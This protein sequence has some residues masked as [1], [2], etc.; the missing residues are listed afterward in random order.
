MS[1]G[2]W[3]DG[4]HGA[5][6][7]FKSLK[8]SALAPHLQQPLTSVAHGDSRHIASAGGTDWDGTILV[9]TGLTRGK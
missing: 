5:E 1:D 8:G 2:T 4:A 7:V 3:F 9:N 6:G